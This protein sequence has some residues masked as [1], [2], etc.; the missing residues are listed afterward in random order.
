MAVVTLT[1]SL[2]EELVIK[3]EDAMLYECN[4]NEGDKVSIDANNKL[5]KS[6]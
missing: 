1:N 5:E 3:A 4:I 2:G 6:Y